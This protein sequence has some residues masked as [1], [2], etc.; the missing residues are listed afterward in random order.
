MKRQ[1]GLILFLLV[2]VSACDY[3]P[4]DRMTRR[5]DPVSTTQAFLATTRRRDCDKAWTFFSP[6]T[7]EKIREQSKRERRYSPYISEAFAPKQIHCR[8]YEDYRPSTVRLALKEER[9]AS[10]RV[11]E[12][13]PDPKSFALPGLTPIGRMDVGRTINLTKEPDGWKILP[14]VPEDPRAKY[15]E[16]TYD[17]GKAVVV[18]SPSKVVDG[19]TKFRVQ[20]DVRMDVEAA[21]LE[22]ALADPLRWPTF[23]PNMI[24][25][26]WTGEPDRL[27]YRPLTVVFS[28]PGGTREA[29]IF[30][31]QSSSTSKGQNF[32]FG[33]G[34][35]TWG[36]REVRGRM[37]ATGRLSWAATF[38]AQPHYQGGSTVHWSQTVSDSMLG[39]QHTVAAQLEAIEQEAKRRLSF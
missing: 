15:G 23:W 18:T 25:S 39:H 26:R 32:S 16:K 8:S 2:W 27:G 28:L 7:Q 1:S 3:L 6:Q 35:E 12:R 10:V 37:A 20:A 38:S 30:L 21:D 34:S 11:M 5:D 22:R 31:R 36:S 9:R 33:F 24:S 13:V 14:H 19:L 29:R 4:W 17:L